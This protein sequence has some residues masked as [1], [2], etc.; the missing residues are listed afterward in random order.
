MHSLQ[1]NSWQTNH[2]YRKMACLRSYPWQEQI[3]SMY[4]STTISLAKRHVMLRICQ[5]YFI[6]KVEQDWVMLWH[7]IIANKGRNG[8]ITTISTK[9]PYWTSPKI[10]MD[11]SVSS[12]LHGNKI[13]ADKDF[14]EFIVPEIRNITG[15][16][17]HACASH[18]RDHKN[19]WH[20]PL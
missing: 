1:R 4:G 17:L 3:H 11:L 15:P 13:I 20:T 19:T 8:S 9:H 12:S 2:T 6:A 7:S 16:S 10:C 14:R 5:K 18:H